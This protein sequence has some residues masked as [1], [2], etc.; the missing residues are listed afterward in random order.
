MGRQRWVYRVEP[1]HF[2]RD[3]S[4]R[5]ER[6]KEAAGFS[7]RGLARELRIDVRLLKRWRNGVKP[8]S[9]HLVALFGLAARLGLLLLLLPEAGE[10]LERGESSVGQISDGTTVGSAIFMKGS[11]LC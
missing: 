8:D 9:A 4:Q 11:C 10:S 1:C 2:P 6:F 3:F 5:L 7:W